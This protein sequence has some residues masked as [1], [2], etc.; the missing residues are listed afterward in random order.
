MK[1]REAFADRL[2][3]LKLVQGFRGQRK[4]FILGS[5]QA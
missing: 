4:V 1:E 2:K 5:K 3:K